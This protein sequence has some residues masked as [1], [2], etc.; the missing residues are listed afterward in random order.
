[1][2]KTKRFEQIKNGSPKQTKSFEKIKNGCLDNA[3]NYFRTYFELNPTHMNTCTNESGLSTE[4]Q[5]S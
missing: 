1:M 5:N 3:W 2:K 4:W